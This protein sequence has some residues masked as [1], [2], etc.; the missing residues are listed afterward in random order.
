MALLFVTGTMLRRPVTS[1]LFIIVLWATVALLEI[2]TLVALGSVSSGLGWGLAA[3][4][5]AGSAASLVCYQLFYGL[6]GMAAFVD[7]A[8]PLVLA[9]LMTGFITLCAR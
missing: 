3:L 4:C 8:L 6:D 2:N 7:G 9:G 1:E 5:L